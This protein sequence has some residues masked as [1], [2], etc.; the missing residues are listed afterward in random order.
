VDDARCRRELVDDA[1][2]QLGRHDQ[3]EMEHRAILASR[4]V[5]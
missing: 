4:T 5:A 1:I 3:S 2:G